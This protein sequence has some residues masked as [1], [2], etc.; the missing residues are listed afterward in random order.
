MLADLRAALGR[1]PSEPPPGRPGTPEERAAIVRR[2]LAERGS[3]AVAEV[4]LE[5]GVS[6]TTAMRTVHA[7]AR[8]RGGII[9]LEP[10]GPTFRVRLWHP[11]RVILD[12]EGWRTGGWAAACRPPLSLLACRRRVH[13]IDAVGNDLSVPRGEGHDAGRRHDLVRVRGPD[14]VVEEATGLAPTAGNESCIGAVEKACCVAHAPQNG[15]GP[16]VLSHPLG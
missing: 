2:L 5:L 11:D 3:L 8:E 6:H 9:V 1:P 4:Q 16:L 10:T 15:A 12:H 7:V 14:E 13:Q